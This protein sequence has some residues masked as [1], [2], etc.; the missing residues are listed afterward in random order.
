MRILENGTVI[1]G[2]FGFGVISCAKE[3]QDADGRA[4][5]TGPSGKELDEVVTETN[6]GPLGADL[7]GG[8][9][10]GWRQVV[11]RIVRPISVSPVTLVASHDKRNVLELEHAPL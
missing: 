7:F 10:S 9:H 11:V 6:Q 5:T 3:A 2:I 4:R 1:D 8:R